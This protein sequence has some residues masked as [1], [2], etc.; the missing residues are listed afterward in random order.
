MRDP[1][2]LLEKIQFLPPDRIAGI[3][4]FV[5]FIAAR[6]Q[7]RAQGLAA[8]AASTPSFAAIWQNPEDNAY[9]A[10]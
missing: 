2:A 1:Q 3:E 5:A 4:N 6:E 8:A 7:A 9:D 10:L